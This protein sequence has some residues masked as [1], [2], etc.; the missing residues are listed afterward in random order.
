MRALE[1]RTAV[2]MATDALREELWA[3]HWDDRIPGTR[4]L[5]ARMR[6]SAQT[7]A[8]AL[9]RLAGEGLLTTGGPRRAYRVIG[10][11]G[12]SPQRPRGAERKEL[13]I[14]VHVEFGQLVEGSRRLLEMLMRRMVERGWL[15]RHQVVDFLHVKRPQSAWD[16]RILVEE[17]TKVVAV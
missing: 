5:A 16:R 3:G 4:V 1:K 14:L 12:P 2:E 15:V 13:L 17:G 11:P 6:V 8:A 7:V 10:N 9:N